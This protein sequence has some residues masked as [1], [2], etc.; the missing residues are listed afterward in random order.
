MF[1]VV[2]DWRTNVYVSDK[3]QATS[4]LTLSLGVRYDY[5]HITPL[6]KNAFQLRLGVACT[7][8]DRT[9][10]RGG[11]GKFHVF[12]STALVSNLWTNQVIGPAFDFDT[13][14]DRSPSRGVRPAHACLNPVGDGQRRAVISPACRAARGASFRRVLQYQTLDAFSSDYNVLELSA[15]K[16]MANRWAGRFTYTL[17]RARDVNGF[18]ET[19]SGDRTLIE[20]R[21]NDDRNPR[22]DYGVANLDNRHAVTAGGNWQAW[23]GLGIGAVFSYYSGNPANEVVGGDANRDELNFDRPVRGRDDA[24]LPIRSP[25]DPAAAPSGTGFPAPTSWR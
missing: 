18:R 1:T 25:L 24:T 5:Q 3:W 6:T 9:V 23:R 15:E 16:R 21:V 20:R 2:D 12:P 13:G 7:A 11:V 22:A 14:Q 17:A 4:Q 8:S 10:I 19:C